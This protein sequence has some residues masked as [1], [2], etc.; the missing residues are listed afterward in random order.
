MDTN[1]KINIF[2]TH[3]VTSANKCQTSGETTF[4]PASRKITLTFSEVSKTHAGGRDNVCIESLIFKRKVY[5]Q[6]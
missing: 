1:V 6:I 4:F 5:A 3:P 2:G